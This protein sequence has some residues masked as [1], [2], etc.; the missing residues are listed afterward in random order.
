MF[1]HTKA[2]LK[3]PEQDP[4]FGL[5]DEGEL[6]ARRIYLGIDPSPSGPG[7]W[8]SRVRDL[9]RPPGLA[10]IV[11]ERPDISPGD[12]DRVVA[13]E[14]S[15]LLLAGGESSPSCVTSD[16]PAVGHWLRRVYSE[17]TDLG[18][19]LRR[20]VPDARAILLVHTGS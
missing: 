20:H 19:V 17:E 1:L 10:A 3:R 12:L 11:W 14:I 8:H 4:T 16:Q 2:K 5:F 13:E 15:A 9:G 6:P 18:T 7:Q